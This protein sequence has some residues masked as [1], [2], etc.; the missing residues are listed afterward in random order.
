MQHFDVARERF[1]VA[2]KYFNVAR[3]LFHVPMKDIYVARNGRV[4]RV[5]TG[6]LLRR[7]GPRLAV[8][9]RTFQPVPKRS[10]SPTWTAFLMTLE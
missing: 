6:T 1:D 5:I 7:S 3:E 8:H 4:R 2:V 10:D 9:R